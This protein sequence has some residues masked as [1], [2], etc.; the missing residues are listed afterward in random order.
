MDGKTLFT[1]ILITNRH[2]EIEQT[3]LWP[4]MGLDDPNSAARFTPEEAAERWNGAS[5][6]LHISMG[7]ETI[8]TTTFRISDSLRAPI[9]IV[10][11]K[12]GRL[13]NGFELG[14]KPLLLTM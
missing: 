2:G 3:V 10:S 6:S 12:D 1:S 11:E 9:V 7:K 8:S 14:T 13:L 5:F 4:Q